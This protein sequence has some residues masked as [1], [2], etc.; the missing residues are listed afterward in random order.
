MRAPGYDP[1]PDLAKLLHTSLLAGRD[2]AAYAERIAGRLGLGED[3]KP[4]TV[5]EVLR[6]ELGLSAARHFTETW[7]ELAAGLPDD[8]ECHM[9]CAEANA[10]ADLWRAFGDPGTANALMLAHSAHDEEG[11]Q[12]WE[13]RS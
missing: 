1:L 13:P 11:D 3:D 8:Y 7:R 2:G 4:E 12:H 5:A 6:E 10:A 9:N